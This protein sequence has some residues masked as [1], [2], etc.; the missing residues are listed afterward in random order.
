VGKQAIREEKNPYGF[1]PYV[2]IPNCPEPNE[3]WGRSDLV[4]LMGIIREY[5]ARMSDRSETIRLHADPPTVF[6]PSPDEGCCVHGRRGHQ[7]KQ[8][9][10]RMT[11]GCSCRATQRSPNSASRSSSVSIGRLA[12]GSFVSGQRRSAG[13]SS[14]E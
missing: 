12:I 14:G 4:D 11:V 8:V 3:F 6:I 7:W 1:I 5:N 10:A 2:H 13:C 9:W